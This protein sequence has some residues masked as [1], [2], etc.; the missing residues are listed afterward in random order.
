MKVSPT[1]LG[2]ILLLE[3]RVFR[4]ERGHFLE[5][6]SRDRYAEHGLPREFVQ[7][8]VSRSRRGVLRGLHFQNPSAQGK[9]VS[10]LEGAVWDVAVDLRVDS[11]TFKQWVGVELSSDSLRQLW[12]PQGFAHG[13]V[14][15]SDEAVFSYKCTAAFSPD[16]ERSLRWDDPELSIEW[17]MDDPLLSPKDATAPLLREL[18]PEHL[19]HGS[20][21][22][23]RG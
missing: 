6:W 5:T 15:L 20:P 7:D 4:D 1:S 23:N 8:N 17:P 13:F 10:V 11:P 3:P 12:I 2:G 16:H 18:P 14:V 22:G 9:L 19:F 21:G